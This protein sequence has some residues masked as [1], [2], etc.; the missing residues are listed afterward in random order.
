[1]GM[2][3]RYVPDPSLRCPEC[4]AKLS[5]WQGKSGPCLLLTWHQGRTEPQVEEGMALISVDDLAECLLPDEFLIW[6]DCC[7]LPHLIYGIGKVEGG[8]WTEFRLMRSS[9]VD[10]Y[11]FDLPNEKRTELKSWLASW[12]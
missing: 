5:G 8:V 6:T 7:E 10:H 3:D 1:M 9:D 2:Y 4:G 12:E 11:F